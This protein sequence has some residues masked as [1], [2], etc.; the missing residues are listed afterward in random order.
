VAYTLIEML[1]VVAVVEEVRV[2]LAAAVDA[3][4]DCDE[5]RTSVQVRL[6]GELNARL[7]VGRPDGSFDFHIQPTD[8]SGAGPKDVRLRLVGAANGT[9]RPGAP[10]TIDL[11]VVGS[12]EL[13]PILTQA[14][15]SLALTPNPS[16]RTADARLL[17]IRVLD[18]CDRGANEGSSPEGATRGAAEPGDD[19][20]LVETAAFAG[21]GLVGVAALVCGGRRR[22]RPKSGPHV[23]P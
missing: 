2:G 1:V 18:P 7:L 6:A 8:L 15:L 17:W 10:L 13:G 14:G 12:S 16:D 21:V 22:S 3:V 9:A 11:P 23:E 4:R 5:E 19:A 20:A